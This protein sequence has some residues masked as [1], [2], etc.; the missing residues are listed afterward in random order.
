MMLANVPAAYLGERLLRRV[1]AKAV[2]RVA[3]VIFALLGALALA[4]PQFW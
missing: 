3:A 1:P 2:R 4:G